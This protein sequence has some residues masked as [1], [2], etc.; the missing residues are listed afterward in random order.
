[1]RINGSGCCVGRTGKVE[2]QM[3]RELLM[4]MMMMMMMTPVR[5]PGAPE[6]LEE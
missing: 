4:M 2:G 3:N 5:E 6:L 1:M